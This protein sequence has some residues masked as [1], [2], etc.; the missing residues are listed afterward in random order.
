M[1]ACLL[2][3]STSTN[4]EEGLLELYKKI[5]PGEPLAVESAESLP[6]DQTPELFYYK[7]EAEPLSR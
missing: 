1:T 7:K 2:Y 3:T 6:S 5:R 4:Y